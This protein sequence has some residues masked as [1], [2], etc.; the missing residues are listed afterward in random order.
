VRALDDELFRYDLLASAMAGCKV[1]VERAPDEHPSYTDG[2]TI[3]LARG[4]DRRRDLAALAV[5]GA[6]V[7]AG[8]L[9]PV[10]MRRLIGRPSVAR[11]YLA[12]EGWRALSAIAD[13][14][15]RGPIAAL[16]RGTEVLT[17]SA[18]ESLA[19][20]LGRRD[21]PEPPEIFGVIRPRRVLGA[22]PADD[23]SP[24]TAQD[25][26]RQ[27][28]VE[29]TLSE[30]DE[31]QETEDQSKILKLFSSPLGNNNSMTQ[32]LFKAIG[33]GREPGSG[34]AGAD[35][36]VGA[37]RTATRRGSKATVS[38]LPVELLPA[39]TS[40]EHGWGWRYPEWDVHTR[41]YRSQWCTVVEVDPR[42]DDLR[43]LDRPHTDDLRRRLARLGVKLERRR[44]QLQG[45]DIDI[46]ATVEAQV[47]LVAGSAPDGRVYVESQRRRR[48]LAVLVLLDI[49]G[50]A[51]DRTLA[52]G[53]VHEQQ[54]A[55]AAAL[56]DAL[57]VLGDRVAL[58]GF[59][60]YGRSAVYLVHVKSFDDVLNGA[61][62]ERLGGLVPGGFTRLGAAIRHGAHVLD[63]RAG[64]DRRLLVVLSDG[65]AYDDGYEGAYGEA[66]ARRALAE[67][68]RQGIGCLCL[69]LG[70]STDPE[71]LRRVFGTAAHASGDRLEDL[72]PDIGRLFQRAMASADLQ[73]RLA[74]RRQR[75][76]DTSRKGVA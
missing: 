22:T 36:R 8:S 25:L 7:T 30:F 32:L 12:I 51:A 23:G 19:E 17:S 66:D 45:D 56:L 16:G 6:L 18:E 13:F 20:A 4:S 71:A 9:D 39:E 35:L 31:D 58:Y 44:R 1:R 28:L 72:A 37:S 24:P 61:S 74:Q 3:Y 48:S 63:T 29:E 38:L 15:P 41:R 70:A 26:A 50:S 34:Q 27:Q 73:R 69:T 67:T 64:T 40:C 75:D 5:Q 59:R 2:R 60:S 11:R 52:C 42:P 53:S 47:E 43:V 57:S 14:L 54:R 76:V 62:F 33:A 68:R 46:D 49:S 55:A 21:V 65:F 10:I